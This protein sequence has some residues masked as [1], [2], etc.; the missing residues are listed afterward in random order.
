MTI[1]AHIQ[2]CDAMAD[3]CEEIPHDP[4]NP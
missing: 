2:W 3:Q 4:T 1:P